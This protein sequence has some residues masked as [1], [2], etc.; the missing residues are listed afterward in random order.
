[1]ALGVVCRRRLDPRFVYLPRHGVCDADGMRGTF[2]SLSSL[3]VF[4]AACSLTTDLPEPREQPSSEDAEDAPDCDADD[5]NACTL[6]TCIDGAAVHEPLDPGTSCDED[7]GSFCDAQGR[8]VECLENAACTN[9][10]GCA[11]EACICAAGHCKLDRCTNGVQD[12]DETDID[13]GGATCEP[14]A[15]GRKCHIAS[16]CTSAVCDDGS[17][18]VP[19]CDDW[20]ANGIESDVDCGGIC[21][22]CTPGQACHDASDCDSGVCA[23]DTLLCAAP[24]CDD[25][26]KNAAETAIDCGGS[27]CDGCGLGEACVTEADCIDPYHCTAGACTL[28]LP[29][30]PH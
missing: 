11:G 24:D 23:S 10:P 17:C 5:A 20:V 9:H 22:D 6:D 7:G 8:C 14:C 30:V 28:A 29:Y 1:V 3:V 2:F 26:V 13:C 27:A 18:A 19:R 25:G 4:V 12:V 21:N 15:N 16:D